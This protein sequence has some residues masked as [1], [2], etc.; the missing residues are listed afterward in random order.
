MTVKIPEIIF[1][2][3]EAQQAKFE[4]E[5][6]EVLKA[7]PDEIK[8]LFGTIGFCL[9]EEDDDETDDEKGNSNKAAETGQHPPPFMQ[10]ILIVSPYDVRP[11]PVRDIYWMDAFTKAKRSKAKLKKLDYLVYV[12][13]SDDPDDCYNFVAHED[14][15]TFE[16]GR[17]SGFD[18]LPPTVAAKSESLRT[19]SENKLVRGIEE[20]KIDLVKTPEDRR[21]HGSPFLEAHE[22]LQAK[23]KEEAKGQPPAK[24]QKNLKQPIVTGE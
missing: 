11:K 1:K 24:K 12:Y 13:G 9:G 21:K 14:F 18:V 20:M 16:Q 23:E 15:V 19:S 8:D 17:A 7:L 10:P 6:L 3:A 5:K 4:K 22:K 2:M